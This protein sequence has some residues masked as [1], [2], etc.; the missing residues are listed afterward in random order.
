MIR[1]RAI[2]VAVA[3]A[4]IGAAVVALV[5]RPDE[6]GGDL[7]QPIRASYPEGPLHDDGRLYFAEMAADRVTE[8]GEEGRQAFFVQPGCG[9]TAIA[10]FGE[11]GYLV[12]C[13]LGR[14]LVAV[15]A[16]GRERRR[17]QA[18]GDGTPLMGPNDAS[19]DGSGGVYF[20]DSGVFAK[21]TEPHGRLFHLGRSGDLRVVADGLWY[22]N[23]VN[24]DESGQHLYVSE[25]L[26]GRVLRYDI[27]TDGT[28]GPQTTFAR[29]PAPGAP[30]RYSAAF[31]E[32][33]PD[34]LEIGPDGHLYVAVYGEG[35]VVRFDERGR[36]RGS[37]ELPTR[38]ATNITFLPDGRAATTGVFS[39]EGP[40]VRGEVRLHRL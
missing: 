20:S 27:R 18:D 38:F 24:V 37:I 8:V 17:W 5:A 40:S 6:R 10:S 14:R 12:L 33:G 26:A 22:P 31:P 15:D 9:P 11:P 23:G 29:L 19:S 16:S 21:D 4:V 1:R 32:T 36:Y 13:H 35:R 28:L 34:G 39:D 3:I 25:H 2:T 30:N 7:A